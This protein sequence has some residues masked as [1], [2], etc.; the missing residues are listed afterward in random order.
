MATN[1]HLLGVARDVCLNWDRVPVAMQQRVL[2]LLNCRRISWEFATDLPSTFRQLM[3]AFDE[4][5]MLEFIAQFAD[6]SF[7]F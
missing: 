7:A 3:E 6:P 1:R 4:R 5:G 2:T